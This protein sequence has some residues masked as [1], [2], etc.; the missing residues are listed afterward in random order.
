MPTRQEV[1]AIVLEWFDARAGRPHTTDDLN[2]LRARYDAIPEVDPGDRQVAPTP[3][4]ALW[5]THPALSS[6]GVMGH[7]H[8][9][10]ELPHG[11]HPDA[12][13]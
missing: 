10:G 1:L 8:L 13:T 2:D 3:N 11:H 9:D 6:D 12:P 4:V 7:A 5:H